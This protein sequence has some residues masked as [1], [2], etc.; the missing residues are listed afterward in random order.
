ME[1]PFLRLERRNLIYKAII[2]IIALIILIIT[3]K[4]LNSMYNERT[5]NLKKVQDIKI[6]KLNQELKKKDEELKKLTTKKNVIKA[7]ILASNSKISSDL[8]EK[9]ASFILKESIKKGNSPY[10]QAALIESESSFMSNV[11]H[12][13]TNV[14]GMSGIYW[15][16]WGNELKAAGI[17]QKKE[18]L[19][20]PF[21]NMRASSYILAKYKKMSNGSHIEALGRYK[22]YSALGKSQAK[23]VMKVAMMLKNKERVA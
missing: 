20:N 4:S 12:A 14:I 5:E 21:V 8:A 6:E 17:L 23:E 11:K 10:V 19:K 15:D 1:H 16:V 7:F 3:F 13:I 18:D 2:L 22:G 9:Y